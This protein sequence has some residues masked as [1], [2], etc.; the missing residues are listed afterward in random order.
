[1]KEIRQTLAPLARIPRWVWLSI[2]VVALGATL[3]LATGAGLEAVCAVPGVR[4]AC[5]GLGLGGVPSAAE[6][7]MWAA[8][9]PGDCEGLRGYLAR[10]PAGAFAIPAQ[11]LLAARVTRETETW[12]PDVKTLPL[13]VRGGLDPMPSEAAARQAAMRRADGE[14]A[15]VCI[16]YRSGEFRLRSAKATPREWRCTQ[17]GQGFICGFDGEAVC[18]VEARRRAVAELCAGKME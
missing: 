7:A 12:A 4:A 17:H 15:E 10:F 16:P 11:R 14:A 8:R 1:V 3:R 2:G 9:K 18:S 13:M 5:G 6:E